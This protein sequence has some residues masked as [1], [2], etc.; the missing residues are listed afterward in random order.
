MRYEAR[1]PLC[2]QFG[3]DW[4]D[5]DEFA[6]EEGGV[7]LS[8]A[9]SP[10]TTGSIARPERLA[11]FSRLRSDRSYLS[12]SSQVPHDADIGVGISEIL[13]WLT[14]DK[15]AIANTA[16][17]REIAEVACD[18]AK[19]MGIVDGKQVAYASALGGIEFLTIDDLVAAEEIILPP[20][21]QQTF[22]DR[23]VLAY[24]GGGRPFVR[25]EIEQRLTEGDRTVLAGLKEIKLLTEGMRDALRDLDFDRF[26]V[27]LSNHASVQ[28]RVAAAAPQANQIMELGLSAGALAARPVGNGGSVVFV[29]DGDPSRL[30]RAVSRSGARVIDIDLDTLGIYLSKG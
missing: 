29:T 23:F 14:L 20:S 7:A 1:T 6:R 3:G 2:L 8:A 24:C 10:Y 28:D 27:C 9:I 11:P 12:Y 4:T 13:V 15:T 22:H 26:A 5:L 16:S 21:V 17:R 30:R 25:R 19:F 18:I